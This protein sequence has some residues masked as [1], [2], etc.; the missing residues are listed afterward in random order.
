MPEPTMEKITLRALARKQR[1]VLGVLM[2]KGF[3][4]PEQYPLTLKSTVS[5]CNQ[6]NN[7][8]PVTNYDE[9]AVAQTLDSLQ[10]IGL[11]GRLHTETGRTERFRHYMRHR[12]DLTEQQLAVMAELL[13]RGRQ[14]MGELRGRA[15]RMVPIDSLEDLRAA[16]QPLLD[17]GL[18]RTN[19]SLD[20][21]GIEVDHNL[22]PPNENHE[23]LSALPTE[24]DRIERDADVNEPRPT[25]AATSAP[26]IHQ[27]PAASSYAGG[28]AGGSASGG[29]E[30]KYH[31]LREEF[32]DFR[33][34]M[35]DKLEQLTDDLNELRRQLGA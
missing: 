25:V 35:T 17:Q 21:R 26:A 15:A 12:T 32:E 6:K 18:I 28:T 34:S 16:L 3:T 13:L 30:A 29:W 7:R 33:L 9:D 8:D 4:T 23:A 14:Q 1:R 2:E 20:R 24:R 10:E 11:I 22:Y 5:G 31:Q 27:P 19:G